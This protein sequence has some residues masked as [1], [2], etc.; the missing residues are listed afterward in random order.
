MLR[1]AR[2]ESNQLDPCLELLRVSFKWLTLRISKSRPAACKAA[3][4]ASELSVIISHADNAPAS[5]RMRHWNS[6]PARVELASA[7]RQSAVL[8]DERWILNGGWGRT[9]T[10]VVSKWWRLYRPLS[11]LLDVTQP[12]APLVGLA[13][14]KKLLDE[15]QGTLL[16]CLQRHL[17]KRIFC[18]STYHLTASSWLLVDLAVILSCCVWVASD[19]TLLCRKMVLPIWL[20]QIT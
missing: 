15:N 17:L 1:W 16:I 5:I 10:Y 9:R 20:A 2:L 3:A 18:T 19:H 7:D 13:P 11:S 8:A 12:L 6:D 4:L 14:A